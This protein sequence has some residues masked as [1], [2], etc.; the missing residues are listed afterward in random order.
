MEFVTAYGGR[1]PRGRRPIAGGHED[2]KALYHAIADIGGVWVPGKTGCH[3]N[4]AMVP[5]NNKE[6]WTQTYKILCWK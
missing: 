1:L 3:L 5:Y 6:H 2:G 4:G